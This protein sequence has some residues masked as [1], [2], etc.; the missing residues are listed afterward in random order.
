[1]V[2]LGAEVRRRGFKALKTNIL[3]FDGE[4]LVGFGP[5]FGRT[6]GHP[7]LNADRAVLRARFTTLWRPSGRGRGQRWGCTWM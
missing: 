3:P 1:V 5:G 2:A 6:P 4:K 7:E